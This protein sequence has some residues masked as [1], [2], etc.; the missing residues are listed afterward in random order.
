MQALLALPGHLTKSPLAS[1]GNGSFAALPSGQ[2]GIDESALPPQPL[3]GGGNVTASGKDADVNF[4]N[5]TWHNAG[6]ATAGEGWRDALARGMA[7]RYV[8]SAICSFQA[9]GGSVPGVLPQ[10]PPDQ[11][12]TGAENLTGLL[13]EKFS[14]FDIDSGGRGG[15]YT[16]QAGFGWTNGVLLWASSRFGKVLTAPV[17]PQLVNGTDTGPPASGTTTGGSA[18]NA[19]P[20]GALLLLASLIGGLMVL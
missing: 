8:S 20:S 7:N 4:A 19:L 3:N 1:G 13:F 11:R 5:G 12:I 10:L 16:V 15:E 6:N 2:L 9:S 17:C 18:R 14:V